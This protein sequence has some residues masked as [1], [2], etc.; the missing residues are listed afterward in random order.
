MKE[1]DSLGVASP[2]YIDLSAF[3]G[4]SSQIIS[5]YKKKQYCKKKTKII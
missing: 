3:K 2:Q 4:F 1:R 5:F